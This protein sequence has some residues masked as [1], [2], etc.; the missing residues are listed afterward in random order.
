MRQFINANQDE[1][2][3]AVSRSGFIHQPLPGPQCV[4]TMIT[5][6]FTCC[7]VKLMGHN[8][9]T[10]QLSPYLLNNKAIHYR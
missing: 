4:C 1:E 3:N 5:V 2:V 7:C 6:G 10:E 9:N 8:M